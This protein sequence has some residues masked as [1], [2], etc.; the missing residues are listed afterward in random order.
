MGHLLWY[1]YPLVPLVSRFTIMGDLPSIIQKKK[2]DSLF[3]PLKESDTIL[4]PLGKKKLDEKRSRRGVEN[5]D[6]TPV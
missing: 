5:I 2:K 4:P 6:R 3:S 1:R